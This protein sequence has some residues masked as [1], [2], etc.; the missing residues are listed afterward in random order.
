MLINTI[1]PILAAASVVYLLVMAGYLLGVRGR[2][3]QAEDAYRR[4]QWMQRFID[5]NK[6][7][8][9]RADLEMSDEGLTAA[10][11]QLLYDVC[12]ALRIDEVNAQRIVG[13]AYLLALRSE[14]EAA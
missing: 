11:A 4:G 5:G 7:R 14:G 10:Q 6:L 12:M 3:R 9:L 13:P 8:T 2:K 1:F